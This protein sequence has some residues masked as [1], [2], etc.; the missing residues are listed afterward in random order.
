MI[1]QEEQEQAPRIPG[2]P[3]FKSYAQGFTVP[4]AI[5][6]SSTQTA[7]YGPNAHQY[8]ILYKDK[9]YEILVEE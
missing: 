3:R 6:V 2:P 1:W 9:L 5:E 7:Y 8:W 4:G